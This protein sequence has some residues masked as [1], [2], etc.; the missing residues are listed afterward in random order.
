MWLIICTRAF[1]LLVH[2]LKIV[3]LNRSYNKVNQDTS[4]VEKIKRINEMQPWG[5]F[6]TITFPTLLPSRVSYKISKMAMDFRIIKS[7]NIQTVCGFY[8]PKYAYV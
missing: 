4:F 8:N 3:L 6:F 1:W 2:F 7:K 5:S